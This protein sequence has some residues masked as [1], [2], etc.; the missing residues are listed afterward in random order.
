MPY[1]MNNPGMKEHKD[2]GQIFEAI[3]EIIMFHMMYNDKAMRYCQ[4]IGFNGFKRLHRYNTRCFL[5]Y[6]LK[7]ENEAF[8]KYRM[9]LDPK[10]SEFNYTAG[11]IVDHLHKWDMKLGE[12]IKKLGMLSNEYREM[13]GKDNCVIGEALGIMCHD[14]EKAGRWFR[15]FSETKSMHDYH[16][17]DDAIHVKMKAM[18]GSTG[19]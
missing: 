15:R 8:D 14:Y 1:D 10:V 12:D 3:D 19:H 4:S 11:D 5:D 6:H 18:E 16:D 13:S 17:L 2:M 7:I 9:I